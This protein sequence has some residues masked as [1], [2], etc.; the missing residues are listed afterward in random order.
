MAEDTGGEKAFPASALKKQ[1]AR[2]EGNIAKSQDLNSGVALAAALL[3]LLLV[4][5]QGLET[6]VQAT[7]YFIGHAHELTFDK[8]PAQLVAIR[9]LYYVAVCVAPLAAMML[10]VGLLLNFMQVGVLVTFKPLQPKFEKLNPIS[11][12]KKFGSLRTLIELLKSLSKLAIVG[13]V[14]WL[15]L[16]G[17]IE[18]LIALMGMTPLTLLPAVSGIIVAVWWRVAVAMIALGILD[19]GYQR[20]QYEQDLRMTREEVKQE[21]KELEGDPHI[22]RRVRQL[23]RQMAMQRMMAEV[24]AAD[25][26]VTNPTQYAVALRYDMA[27]MAAPVVVAKGMRLVAERIRAIGIEHEVPIVQKPELARTLYRTI[28]VG[29]PIPETLFR[30]VAEVLS[31][32][33]RIDRRAEKISEREQMMQQTRMAV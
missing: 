8:T 5:R 4:G 33:Y 13:F 30:A 1:R 6:L 10:A 15:T 24:P 9:A 3:A 29:Q 28:E 17:R 2:E 19:F 23:Q 20:W 31:F 7:Q 18:E 25:V 32:V 11:G 12:F 14:V 21:T 16:R 26:I 22:K 27:E